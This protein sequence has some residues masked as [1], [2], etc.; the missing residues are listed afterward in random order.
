MDAP[1]LH[2]NPLRLPVHPAVTEE[3]IERLVRRF[4]GKV[5]RDPALGPIFA[6]AIGEDW[7]PHL[8][9]MFAFWS[10]V[11]RMTGRY[12]GKPVPAHLRLKAIT[13]EHFET[14]LA[15]FR[16]TAAELCG[17]E[18]WGPEVAA[19]FVERAERIAESLQLALFY[20]PGL[21]PAFGGAGASPDLANR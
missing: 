5:R 17:P 8:E 1:R 7:E 13:P 19:L 4:Y 16:E 15:L 9:K 10:S 6:A 11:M 18:L 21:S 3:L 2:P 12:K 14:W 20:K